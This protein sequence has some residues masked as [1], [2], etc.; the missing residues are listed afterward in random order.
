MVSGV[1][2]LWLLFWADGS[3]MQ[4]AWCMAVHYRK[5]WLGE[6]ICHKALFL[7]KEIEMGSCCLLLQWRKPDAWEKGKVEAAVHVWMLRFLSAELLLSCLGRVGLA[8]F[9]IKW[10]SGVL[11]SGCHVLT[12][13]KSSEFFPACPPPPVRIM[14]RSYSVW[15]L[16]T[17]S[18]P[19]MCIPSDFSE[20]PPGQFY[21][22]ILKIT[23]WRK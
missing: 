21:Y 8:W 3:V 12:S 13:V 1:I 23:S 6:V 22:T 2:H 14:P 9:V 16:F 10:E 15:V 19:P 11:C 17:L 20:L 7:K 5:W 18:V 4:T